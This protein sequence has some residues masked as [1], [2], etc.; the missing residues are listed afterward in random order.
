MPLSKRQLLDQ[1]YHTTFDIGRLMRQRM[2]ERGD[3]DTNPVQLHA[4]LLIEQQP[5][6]T[7][8][9]LAKHLHMTSPSATSLVNR[10]VRQKLV[11]RRHDRLNRKIVRLGLTPAGRET[12]AKMDQLHAEVVNSMFGHLSEEQLRHLIELHRA[13]L[14]QPSPSTST[15]TL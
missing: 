10:L 8:S 13:M 9:G 3:C 4:L 7:M 2:M 5:T 14:R 1:L 11:T 12:I 15:P 6:L